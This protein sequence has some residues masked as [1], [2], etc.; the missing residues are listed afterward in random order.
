M[1]FPSSA[2]SRWRR[3]GGVLA[4]REVDP[5]SVIVNDCALDGVLKRD[6]RAV[7]SG[8]V[9]DSSQTVRARSVRGRAKRQSR[10]A[11]I[12]PQFRL[13]RQ[14]SPPP[15]APQIPPDNAV[16][17][18]P[19]QLSKDAHLGK[20]GARRQFCLGHSWANAPSEFLTSAP[21]WCQGRG[22]VPQNVVRRQLLA[23]CAAGA[24]RRERRRGRGSQA[25][26]GGREQAA[27]E[28]THQGRRA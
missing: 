3:S 26:S 16:R 14:Q 24:A 15:S 11:L 10:A 9:F 25:R 7:V 22:V 27:Q 17:N 1:A 8:Y 20:P 6:R 2:D 23:A 12:S 21:V 13:A 19:P 5:G 4:E 28:V 18:G